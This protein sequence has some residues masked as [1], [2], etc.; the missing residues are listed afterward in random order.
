MSSVLLL[1]TL[2]LWTSKYTEDECRGA[3]AKFDDVETVSAIDRD[4]ARL[5]LVPYYRAVCPEQRDEWD[6]IELRLLQSDAV[7][8]RLPSAR[9]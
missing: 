3:L 7:S 4:V 9:G 1:T 5:R 6:E 8:A 2:G